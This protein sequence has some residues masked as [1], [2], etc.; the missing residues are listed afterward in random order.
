MMNDELNRGSMMLALLRFDGDPDEP[1]PLVG[2]LYAR[3]RSGVGTSCDAPS[4]ENFAGL[5][6]VSDKTAQ[7]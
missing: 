4:P 3:A 1:R 6:P 5:V 2:S 7:L